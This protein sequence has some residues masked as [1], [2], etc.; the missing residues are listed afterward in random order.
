MS[1]EHLRGLMGGTPHTALGLP[2][3][4]VSQ[5]PHLSLV[6]DSLEDEFEGN[7]EATDQWQDRALCAQTDPEAFF[8]EKGGST[9]EAKKI[10]LGC[11]VRSECLE[12]ALGHDERFGIWGGL[13]ERERRRLGRTNRYDTRHRTQR[14]FQLR[15]SQRAEPAADVQLPGLLGRSFTHGPGASACL[16][17]PSD[18]ARDH[19]SANARRRDRTLARTPPRGSI[20]GY[21]CDPSRRS[22][23]RPAVGAVRRNRGRARPVR[24]PLHVLT[25]NRTDEL[26]LSRCLTHQR[27]G[28]LPL[29]TG[30]QQHRRRARELTVPVDLG[31]CAGLWPSTQSIAA[32][33]CASRPWARWL[34][35]FSSR[36][37]N[38]VAKTGRFG[39]S[40]QLVELAR[41][42]IPVRS[43]PGR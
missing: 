1:Y 10:C 15:G 8:P 7:E 41:S 42:P 9:R 19:S 13:S 14:D 18:S 5:R 24:V 37:A 17:D 27:L 3:T 23:G 29:P 4:G 11:E 12:Y 35:P 34:S 39:P 22:K 16:G 43:G 20:S 38:S 6:P 32:G 25:H 31:F 21:R 36:R 26:S 2:M 33:R 30:R 28:R 40:R